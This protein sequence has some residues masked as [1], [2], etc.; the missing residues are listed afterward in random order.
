MSE[1]P[2]KLNSEKSPGAIFKAKREEYGWE[3]EDVATTLFLSTAQIKAVENDE[4]DKLPGA[5]YIVG[6]WRSYANLLKL[7]ISKSI[8]VHKSR[9]ENPSAAIALKPNHQR[10]H[11]HQEKSRKKSALL[12][13]VLSG[14]FLS[15]IWYWQNP[16]DNPLNQWVE[17]QSN[18]QLNILNS[19]GGENKDSQDGG[20]SLFEIENSAI[21]SLPEPNFSDEFKNNDSLESDDLEFQ[22]QTIEL[23][24]TGES[25]QGE[26]LTIEELEI[27]LESVE[28]EE[29]ESGTAALRDDEII[30]GRDL[31]EQQDQSIE[32][33][34]ME[35]SDAEIVIEPEKIVIKENNATGSDSEITVTNEPEQETVEQEFVEQETVEQPIKVAL[36]TQSESE[37]EALSEG[38]QNLQSVS[39]DLESPNWIIFSIKKQTW[40]D[41]RDLRGEKLVYRTVSGGEKLELN[42]EPPFSIFVGTAEGVLVRYL[43]EQVSFEPHKSGL[44]ARFK[45]GKRE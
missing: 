31:V 45:V 18:R 40:L 17:N 24:G 8:D 41:V 23:A 43:G 27:Q 32:N 22:S 7:D 35:A 39:D 13:C 12:F 5:T 36:V 16:D 33:L 15:G 38:D 30:T 44:F 20:V 2:A 10:A 26:E 34:E 9:L 1:T 4:F 21:I 11:G 28:V 14:L 37:I 29:I 3:V 25:Q 6:Y 42:G 19:N